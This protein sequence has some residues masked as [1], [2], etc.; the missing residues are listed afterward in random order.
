MGGAKE[1]PQA[2]VIVY[3]CACG[4]KHDKIS[5][6]RDKYDVT[7]KFSDN[8]RAALAEHINYLTVI[9]DVID[10]YT[11]V[12]AFPGSKIVMYLRSYA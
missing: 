9:G 1:K 12:I 7:V 5:A 10:G 4:W 2:I 6:L 3:G 8:D 11:P